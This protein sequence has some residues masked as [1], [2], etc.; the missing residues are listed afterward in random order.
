MYTT[1]WEN[2]KTVADYA[3]FLKKQQTLPH[4]ARGSREIHLLFD[5][6]RET[7]DT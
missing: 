4:F 6:P 3:N 5:V 2:H 7:K 1:P